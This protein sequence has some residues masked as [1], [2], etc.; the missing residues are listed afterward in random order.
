MLSRAHTYAF[1]DLS[2]GSPSPARCR[3]QRGTDRQARRSAHML[4]E[5]PYTPAGQSGLLRP[6][7]FVRTGEE[8]LRR[9]IEL[10]EFVIVGCSANNL[11]GCR[12]IQLLR[13]F[14]AALLEISDKETLR[15][16]G[17]RTAALRF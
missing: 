1:A 3:D 13:R 11:E 7:N 6:A 16:K 9:G 15:T 12:D 4:N 10:H 8:L 5:Y 2:N 14:T 17:G